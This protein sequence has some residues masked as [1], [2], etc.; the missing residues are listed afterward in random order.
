MAA[1]R[2]RGKF[3]STALVPVRRSDSSMV[4]SMYICISLT[5][6]QTETGEKTGKCMGQIVSGTG[7]VQWEL[8]PV[9]I[10]NR[11]NG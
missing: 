7:F 5:I 11:W 3:G 9:R 2:I 1:D 6:I 8:L 10:R 4:I